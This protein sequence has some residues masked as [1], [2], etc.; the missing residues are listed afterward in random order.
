MRAREWSADERAAGKCARQPLVSGQHISHKTSQGAQASRGNLKAFELEDAP[1]CPLQLRCSKFPC[2]C[3]RHLRHLWL[4][5][6][7]G[8]SLQGVGHYLQ[9]AVWVC[10]NLHRGHLPSVLGALALQKRGLLLVDVNL[11]FLLSIILHMEQ[12]LQRQHMSGSKDIACQA[13]GVSSQFDRQQDARLPTELG[14]PAMM[15]YSSM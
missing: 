6:G 7:P 14:N 9:T 4:M 5:D 2:R 3:L 1:E 11:K 15:P 12:A 10:H 8:W 13:E